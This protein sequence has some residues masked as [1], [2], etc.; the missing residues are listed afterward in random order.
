[1]GSGTRIPLGLLLVAVLIGGAASAAELTDEQQR[2]VAEELR[3]LQQDRQ[4]LNEQMKAFDARIRAL[5]SLMLGTPVTESAPEAVAAAPA[6]QSRDGA[7]N[8]PATP[9]SYTPGKG[10]SLAAGEQGEV[11]FSV[12]TYARYLNNSGLDETYTDSFGRPHTVESRNDVQ[13]QKLTLNFKG[14][15]FDPKFRYLFYTWTSNTSQGDPAQVVVAGNLGY[16]FDPAFNLYAGIGALPSTRST[17]YTFP[18]W[19]K[20]DHRTIADEFFR[21]SYTSGI[22]ASGE[23]TKGLKY[24]AMLGNNL[25]QLGVNANQLDDEFN[26]VSTALWWMPTTGEYGPGEGLGDYEYH[27]ELATLLGL[28]FTRSREDAQGQADDEGFEN[29]Q[30]RLSDGTLIFSGDPFGSGGDIR[31]A[32]YQMAAANAGFKYRGWSVEAEYYR[33]WVDDFVTTGPIPVREL[34]DEGYQLQASAMLI[35]EAL[36]AYVGYSKIYGEYGDPY[37]VSVGVNW[38]PFLRREVRM[39]IQGL[40]LKDSPVGYSSVPFAVGGNGWVMTTDFIVAF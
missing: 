26:T 23:L 38:F 35:P 17:N 11:N 28:H 40:Y 4:Q 13:F 36:Q 9:G 1:M 8:K 15:L 7:G 32:T 19:L 30:I 14:W 2:Q 25:S 20:N 10:F 6:G 12:Y 29:S 21:G 22:W 39:N 3:R 31:K 34:D 16:Q 24:R 37:D 27:E 5:E 18:N 33:R